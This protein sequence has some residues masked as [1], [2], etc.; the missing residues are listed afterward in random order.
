MK[1]IFVYMF[2][3]IINGF[4]ACSSS[5]IFTKQVKESVQAQM[6][7]YPAST[8][9][10]L[11]KN[12]FQDKFGPGHLA[13]NAEVADN[14]LRSELESMDT[15]SNPYYVEITGWE[16]RFCRVNLSLLK[17][18][19]IPYDVFFATFME[20]M[21]S[22][23]LPDVAHWQKEWN[24]IIS[25]IEKMNLNLPNYEQD[26]AKIDSLLAEGKYVIHHS[27]PYEQ[28]YKPHYRLIRTDI[29]EKELKKYIPE[30]E[31]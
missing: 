15:T 17:N 30:T 16:Y 1:R 21:N 9:C 18:N 26:K 13:P 14:Y 22:L 23:E 3:V 4:I 20:S 28:S 29:F 6:D 31:E 19:I 12:F 7:K 2:F 25:I 24:N 5:D 10:D 11:Y 8:L 27:E